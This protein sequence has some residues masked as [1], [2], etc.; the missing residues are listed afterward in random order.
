MDTRMRSS[1]LIPFRPSQYDTKVE[2]LLK[3]HAFYQ[4]QHQLLPFEQN[5]VTE[6]A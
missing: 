2:Y 3:I 1:Q 4:L 6:A 5:Y